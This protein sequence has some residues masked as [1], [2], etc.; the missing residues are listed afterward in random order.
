[1]IV[2]E[3]AHLIWRLRNERV[4]QEKDLAANREI[5]NCWIRA[6]SNRLAIDCLMTNKKKYSSKAISKLLV[7]QTWQKVLYEENRLPED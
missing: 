1:I 6:M 5:G 7:L 4:I 3:S 2:S